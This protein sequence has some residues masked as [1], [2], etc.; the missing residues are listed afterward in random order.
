VAIDNGDDASSSE[1]PSI[2]QLPTVP[3]LALAAPWAPGGELP[4]DV[5]CDGLNQAPAL[6]WSAAP[7]G[8]QE[9]ALGLLDI[10]SPEFDHWFLTGLPP[11]M[12]SIDAGTLPA[13]ASQAVNGNSIAGYAGPCPPLETTHTY[14]FTVY[15]LNASLGDISAM[16][17]SE[18][19]GLA[20]ASLLGQAGISGFFSRI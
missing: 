3:G 19:R 17:V 13:G 7:E 9:I 5:T 10:T 15:Y 11:D 6:S 1:S 8:T 16:P 14:E 4:L 20:E 12:Q 2:P 18:A